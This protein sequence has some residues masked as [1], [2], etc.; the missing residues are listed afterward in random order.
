MTHTRKLGADALLAAWA[1]SRYE[2][3][4]GTILEA[5]TFDKYMGCYSSWTCDYGVKA[6][7]T[8]RRPDGST[9][10]RF[11]DYGFPQVLEQMAEYQ[12]EHANLEEEHARYHGWE[13]PHV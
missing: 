11:S 8:F 3:E 7:F 2:C 4:P 10:E 9:F 6:T 13:E 5:V 1:L 12:A